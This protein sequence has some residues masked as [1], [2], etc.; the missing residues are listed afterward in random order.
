MSLDYTLLYRQAKGELEVLRKEVSDLAGELADRQRKITALVKTVNALAPLAGQ[1]AEPEASMEGAG[2]TESIREIL[3]VAGGPLRAPEIRDRLVESG[4]DLSGYSNPLAVI[5][6]TLRRLEESDQVH[7]TEAGGEGEKRQV[8][9]GLAIGRKDRLE[10]L[11]GKT[12]ELGQSHRAVFGRSALK[13]AGKKP[14][15]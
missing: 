12:I 10:P 2:L 15:R 5:H 8:I 4:F 3:T 13:R 1:G 9:F 6:T 11:S 7:S 14:S